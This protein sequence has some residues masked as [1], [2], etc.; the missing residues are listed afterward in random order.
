MARAHEHYQLKFPPIPGMEIEA[1][2]AASAIA[3]KKHM[4]MEKV[5]DVSMAVVE[6]FLNA[7]EHGHSKN[8]TIYLT[9][10]VIGEPEHEML[11][12]TVRDT[13][14][15]I[16]VNQVDTPRPQ[17]TLTPLQKRGWGLKLIERLMDET[18]I[19]SDSQGTTVTMSKMCH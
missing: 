2:R 19:T 16:P 10:D 6:A 17:Q 14:S 18:Q 8:D 3:A 11:R 9:V 15:G 12:I 7:L 1:G 4:S 5:D 13:G